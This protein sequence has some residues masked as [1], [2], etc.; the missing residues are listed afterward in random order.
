MNGL[1]RIT[2]LALV[3]FSTSLYS[4]DFGVISGWVQSDGESKG[5][6]EAVIHFYASSGEITD[7]VYTLPNGWFEKNLIS[8]DYLVSA[9][10]GNYIREY[11]PGRYSESEAKSIHISPGQMVTVSFS[12]DRGGWI[13]G[14]FD[15]RG[16]EAHKGL[17]IA[18]KVDQP[19]AGWYKSQILHGSYPQ[20]YAITGLIPG[21]YKIRAQ[22][23]GKGMVYYPDVIDENDA[24]TVNVV[25]DQ[26]VADISFLMEPVGFG[27]VSGRVIDLQTGEGLPDVEMS[28]YQWQDFQ[29]DPNLKTT[30]TEIDGDFSLQLTSGNYYLSA[31]CEDCIP[32]SGN[33]MVYYDNKLDPL[34]ADPVTVAE[35]ESV[36]QLEFRFDFSN[37]YNLSVSG[38]V[39]DGQTGDGLGGVLI[40]ALDYFFGYTVNFAYSVG[41]G[42][43]SIDNLASGSYLISFSRTNV[44]PYFYP[45]S[46]T[47]Q[48]AEVVELTTNYRGIQTEAITQDYGNLGLSIA[49]R[50]TA[51]SEPLNSA[52]IYAYPLGEDTPVAFARTNASGE[53]AI[54]RGLVPGSYTVVCDLF[55]YDYEV[56]PEIVELD[57][58]ENPNAR[59]INFNLA[60]PTTEVAADSKP[61]E[62]IEVIG[63]YP[64]P[65]NA[66]TVLRIYSSYTE[67]LESG[68]SVFDILGRN[69]GSKSITI[70]P[71]INH[72]EWG[73]NDFSK[74]VSS[75]IYFYRIENVN[76]T[77]RMVLLK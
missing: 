31:R 1:R 38:R 69:V 47:W 60:Q 68:I 59:N 27:F 57:M 30:T 71:G 54:I 4:A 53:Y 67:T 66:R 35:G 37:I 65:F 43:F 50:V 51:G 46:E 22:A 33:I 5:I 11:Y 14:S 62:L 28:A 76:R 41:S 6:Q 24:V 13:G 2:I 20:N 42:D 58:L 32:G 45:A 73:L 29:N 16:E 77:F 34:Q 64:N 8:G 19:D 23:T 3:F 61:P 44:I 49:G 12:L 63:N 17:V 10:K 36:E 18:L 40:E 55:G 15:I 25:E 72:I 52:R 74:T 39:L 48:N 21:T 70:N 75:G 9:E 26:G 7:S 56:F